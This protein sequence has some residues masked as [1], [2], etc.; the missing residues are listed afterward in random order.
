[1]KH[2]N[3]FTMLL[4]VF[5]MTIT[6]CSTYNPIKLRQQQIYNSHLYYKLDPPLYAGDVVQYRL[7]NGSKHSSTVKKTTPQGIVT[8]SDELIPYK[9]ITSLER[10]DFSKGKTAAA[11][12]AG[13]GVT[14]IVIAVVFV[15]AASAG[16]AAALS[17]S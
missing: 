10:K 3:W 13:A 15:A 16:V 6:G 17:A 7:N 9:D 14:V 8:S 11:I 12:G 1:M 2:I 5:S 4:I